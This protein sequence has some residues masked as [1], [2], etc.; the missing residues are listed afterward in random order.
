MSYEDAEFRQL[1]IVGFTVDAV[2]PLALFKEDAG[3]ITFPLWLEMSDI[4][5]ITADLVAGRLSGKSERKDL[6][7]S[8]LAT[9]RMT[10]TGVTIDGT[11]CDG[12][13]A[14]VCLSGE[15]EIVKVRVEI[16]TALLTA[17]RFKLPVNISA[18][19]LASSALVDQR[20]DEP[21]EMLD[22]QRF[23]EILEKMTPEEMGKYPM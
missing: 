20:T 13:L 5:T 10:V 3:E 12:Y 15:D 23:L 22:E 18:K 19:A 7:D 11:A 17:I 4:L 9:M 16:V 14:D 8:L 1:N 6:L 21:V 2:Q